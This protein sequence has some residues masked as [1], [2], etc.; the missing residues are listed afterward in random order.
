VEPQ[1]QGAV[2]KYVIDADL[3]WPIFFVREDRTLG[4]PLL[5]AIEG[6]RGILGE[7]TYAPLGGQS[8]FH[9]RVKWPG[10]EVWKRQVQARD[11]TRWRNPITMAKFAQHVGRC[12]SDFFQDCE[13][14]PTPDS[15]WKV[16][17]GGIT[18]NEVVV[19][20][21]IHVSSGSWQPILALTKVVI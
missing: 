4:L 19:L 17:T 9:L 2:K 14:R 5:E 15:K 11:D 20:G 8:T 18:P 3:Q 16:G 10:Y 12:V 7:Q 21:A 6:S 13:G 1:S